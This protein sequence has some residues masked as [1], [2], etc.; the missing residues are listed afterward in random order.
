[1]SVSATIIFMAAAAAAVAERRGARGAGPDGWIASWGASDV[2]PIGQPDQLPD[3][4]SDCPR[5]SAGGKQVRVRFSNETGLY[6]LVIGAAH[7]AKP[8]SEGPEGTVDAATDRALTFG[9]LGGTI[10]SAGRGGAVGPGRH[11]RVA[12]AIDALAISLFVAALDRTLSHPSGRGW[13]QP[14]SRARGT[15][16][17]V[18]SIP[19]PKT[20][21][22]RFFINEVDVNASWS[23]RGRGRARRSPTSP[24][25]TALKSTPTSSLARPVGGAP[26]NGP[27]GSR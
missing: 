1:M 24:T 11:G 3:I 9:K 22:S 18:P 26:G 15:S 17:A 6:P 21:T 25:A 2:F 13:R 27:I 8:A 14:T 7:V 10:H 12:A 20:S 4:A 19:S 5:L 23:A 16:M